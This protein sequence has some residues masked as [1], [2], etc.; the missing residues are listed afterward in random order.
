LPN[1]DRMPNL[2]IIG[3][4]KAGTTALYHY[5]S[6]H[7]QVFLSRVKEPMFF[8]R[9][10]YY[11]R[12]QD[13]Y[14]NE[15]FEGA[16]DYPVRAEATPHYLY[17]SEKVAPRIKEVYRERPVK[18]IV[19]F[20]DPVSRAYSWYW[21]MVREGRED[22]DF[23]EALRVEACR[24]RQ[25]RHELYQLGSMVYG[26][27]A[28]SRY[29]SLLQ[30]YLEL[31]SLENFFFVFQDDLKFR[32]NE[33]CDEIFEFLGIES[34]IQIN[35]SKSNPAAMPRFR[36]LHKTLKQRSLFKEFIKPFMPN[37]VR[38]PLKKKMMQ[39]N[40]KETPYVPLDPQLAHELRLSFRT[41]IE[42]LEKI[43]GRELSSWK[44]E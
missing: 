27:S 4:A 32:V 33:T 34:S 17:W 19:S 15:Y 41:E 18:F 2:F 9:E 38:R 16:E 21:N 39:A 31:F 26:Y 24:L 23:D 5:L 42:K 25:N 7:P 22:L 43:T 14:E 36:L 37:R 29:A 12:G 30:P 8:S 1:F 6:Q 13:W 20:R 11:A 40:L 3:A 10:E 35:T 44:A 28:G